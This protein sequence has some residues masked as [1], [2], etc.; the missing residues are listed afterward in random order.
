VLFF[1]V[2]VQHYTVHAKTTQGGGHAARGDPIGLHGLEEVLQD[3]VRLARLQATRP[4]PPWANQSEAE[5]DADVAGAWRSRTTANRRILQGVEEDNDGAI[6]QLLPGPMAWC[7]DPLAVNAG[8]G[9]HCMYVC[10]M[11]QHH[12]FLA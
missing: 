4:S 12:Y 6:M 8:G 11:L 2:L 9:G 5:H 7:D 1:H 3:P 10:E